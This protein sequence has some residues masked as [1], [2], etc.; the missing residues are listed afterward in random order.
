MYENAFDDQFTVR[1]YVDKAA[2]D[3]VE[4]VSNNL[5]GIKHVVGNYQSVYD[6]AKQTKANVG[7]IETPKVLREIL[8]MN[9]NLIDGNRSPERYPPGSLLDELPP[10][11]YQMGN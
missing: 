2:K 7:R 4:C 10:A 1:Q 8:P 9:L 6:L 5:T 3:I 11:D